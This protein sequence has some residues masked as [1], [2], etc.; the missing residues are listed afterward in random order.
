MLRDLLPTNSVSTNTNLCLTV[1]FEEDQMHK[2][3]SSIACCAPVRHEPHHVGLRAL[4][5]SW[6]R[7]GARCFVS[8]R[9][10]LGVSFAVSKGPGVQARAGRQVAAVLL[11]DG[12]CEL[13]TVVGCKRGGDESIANESGT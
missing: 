2:D 8:Q 5:Q 13:C 11:A 6:Y 7:I 4:C 9:L 12:G 3:K 10:F 1:K